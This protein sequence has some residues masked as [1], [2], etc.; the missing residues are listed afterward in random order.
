M[1]EFAGNLGRA[2]SATR[3]DVVHSHFW[4]SGLATA[5]AA[6]ALGIPWA[7]TYHALGV[8]KQRYQGAL[9][10]SP[11]ERLAIEQD[12]A[13]RAGLLIATSFDECREL[14]RMGARRHRI[15]RIPCGVDLSVFDPAGR[16]AHRSGAR[17]RVVVV[18]RLVERKGIRDVIEAMAHLH[19]DVE[20][21]I[22]GGPPHGLLD[23]DP[24]ALSF[25]RYAGEIGVASRVQLIGALDRPDVAALMR[26]A[27]VVC[28]CP[29]YEPF[30]L[31]AVEA[32]ACGVPV[33]ATQV[34]GLA[35]TVVHGSTGLHVPPRDPVA[36]AAAIDAIIG[37]AD[38]ATRLS[39]RARF[40]AQGYGWR[41]VAAATLKQL[42]RLAVRAPQASTMGATEA[43]S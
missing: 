38:L 23:A 22:A 8:V 17:R 16:T 36:I 28:C 6:E 40:R 30:G 43:A 34:G 21:V 5:H 24:A 19:G 35:E 18:S 12:V 27:D 13:R 9:D 3:P 41:A 29:W 39:Q 25:R 31:V 2:W 7:H 32:M 1:A 20:L 15:V 4:M 14:E 33:V 37:D 11:S 10:T 26:S 42:E